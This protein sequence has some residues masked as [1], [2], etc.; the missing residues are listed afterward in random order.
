MPA[1]RFA[2]IAC[3]DCKKPWVT[4]TRFGKV[5]CKR[6][7][8]AYTFVLRQPLWQGDNAE[9]ARLALQAMTMPQVTT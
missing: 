1:G 2:V 6:C 8:K 4:E 3:S 9:H 5:Y 7:G